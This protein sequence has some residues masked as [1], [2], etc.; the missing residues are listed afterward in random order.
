M[1]AIQVSIDEDLLRRLDADPDVQRD[2]RSAVLRR[3]VAAYL[4]ERREQRISE[5]YRRGYAES[6]GIGAEFEGW[7][8]QGAWPED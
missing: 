2:G 7:E 8:D 6:G 4:R 1:K 3:A 5:A